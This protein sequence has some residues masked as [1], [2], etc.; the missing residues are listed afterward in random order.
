MKKEKEK[1]KQ[2][3]KKKKGEYKTKDLS[4]FDTIKEESDLPKEEHKTEDF[5]PWGSFRMQPSGIVNS[6]S[7]KQ[8]APIM[9]TPTKGARTNFFESESEEV[10][11]PVLIAGGFRNQKKVVSPTGLDDYNHDLEPA[12]GQSSAIVPDSESQSDFDS[13]RHEP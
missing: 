3:K 10:E 11:N 7:L 6:K 2:K 4:D 13:D 9:I 1:R 8:G 5:E 12:G